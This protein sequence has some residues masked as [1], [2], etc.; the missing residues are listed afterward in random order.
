MILHTSAS[1]K[2]LRSQVYPFAGSNFLSIHVP[3]ATPYTYPIVGIV[4]ELLQ[5]CSSSP[6]A[7]TRELYG[8][9]SATSTMVGAFDNHV[10]GDG[11][12][13]IPIQLSHFLT[14]N[15]TCTART[16]NNSNCPVLKARNTLYFVRNFA[17][18][19]VFHFAHIVDHVL[20]LFTEGIVRLTLLKIGDKCI[21]VRMILSLV[22]ELHPV[23]DVW[24][25]CIC[26]FMF[27]TWTLPKMCS[28]VNSAT[29]SLRG[30]R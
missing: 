29:N 4:E 19:E 3:V 23:L 2:D 8:T 6:I 15:L 7:R 10:V 27:V 14:R 28:F 25:I 22:D 17:H 21:L 5:F 18:P 26:F 12:C 16:I 11:Q 1:M 13:V 9:L 30:R 20:Q 24:F